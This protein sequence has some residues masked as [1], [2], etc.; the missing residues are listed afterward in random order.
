MR[1]FNKIELVILLVL[2]AP[3]S[4]T[5]MTPDFDDTSDAGY[6]QCT[7]DFCQGWCEDNYCRKDAGLSDWG[8]CI[9]ACTEANSGC[10]CHDIGCDPTNCNEWCVSDK[11]ATGGVCVGFECLCDFEPD[12]DLDSG[13]DSGSGGDSGSD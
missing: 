8:A 6:V 9:G 1:L 3:F 4:P 12:P 10:E 2:I 7:D 11:D 5:C 13:S